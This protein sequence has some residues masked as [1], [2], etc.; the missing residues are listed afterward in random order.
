MSKDSLPGKN[1]LPG[2]IGLI[3]GNIGSINQDVIHGN[4]GGA[5]AQSFGNEGLG[6]FISTGLGLGAPKDPT[7]EDPGGGTK[8][9]T[10]AETNTTAIQNQLMNEQNS[11]L[12]STM[13]TS[14]RGAT[15]KISTTSSMLRGS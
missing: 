4:L 6:G 8:T 10:L 2:K 13:L 11:Y 14:G 1:S 7:L 15:D 9:P 12:T 3:P 5:W